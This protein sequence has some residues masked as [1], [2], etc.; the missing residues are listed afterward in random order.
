MKLFTCPVCQQLLYFENSQCTKCG[1]QLAFV[2]EQLRLT[3]VE[4]AG[5][6]RTSPVVPSASVVV[7]MLAPP[8]R[9]QPVP[10]KLSALSPGA[11]GTRANPAS[12]RVGRTTEDTGS[13][14]YS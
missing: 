2:P 8:L 11:S 12:Q 13:P 1:H 6:S 3:A 5:R 14:R 10:S 4:P 9:T 7:T